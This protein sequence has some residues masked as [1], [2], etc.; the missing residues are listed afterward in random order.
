MD[1]THIHLVLT[2]FPIIGV[3]IG[4]GIL[5]YGLISKK[6]AINKVALVI[7]ILMSLITIPV[8]LTGGEAEEAIE[9]IGGVSENMIEE[10]EELAEVAIWLMGI[11]GLLSLVSLFTLIKKLSFAKII[12]IL[13]FVMA[14]A[15]LGVFAQVGN[16]GGQIRH[17]EIRN[18][19]NTVQGEQNNENSNQNEGEEDDD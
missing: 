15:T 4:V 14:L 7:I 8:F 17:T 13:A 3:L 1:A 19:N 11:L 18:G 16:L 5:A 6:D 9:N 10:H 2:H 12:T